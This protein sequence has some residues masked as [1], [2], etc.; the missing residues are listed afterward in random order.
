MKTRKLWLTALCALVALGTAS[1]S[2]SDDSTKSDTSANAQCGNGICEADE[3]FMFC[4]ADCQQS[5]AS[6]CGNGYCETDETPTSCP[7]DCGSLCSADGCA[8]DTPHP[9]NVGTCGNN[10]CESDES[11]NSCPEDCEAPSKCGNGVCEPE[12]GES[13]ITCS[14]DCDRA[15]VESC[16]N[17][18]CGEGE[19]YD[20][21]PDDC[22]QEVVCGDGICNV[23]GGENGSNCSD[24]CGDI[25]CGDDICMVGETSVTCP[26]D[27]KVLDIDTYNAIS[28][29]K[30]RFFYDLDIALPENDE[31]IKAGTKTLSNDDFFRYPY[32]S[33]LRT[34]ET[35]HPRLY[36]MTIP[37][38]ASNISFI[39]LMKNY[40]ETE[41]PGFSAVSAAFFRTSASITT[42]DFPTPE[43]SRQVNSCFQIV[44]VEKTSTHYGERVPLY[45]TFHEADTPSLWAANTLVLRPVPGAAMNPGD[46][47]VALVQDCLKS[48]S[49][50][51]AQSTKLA[52]IFKKTAPAEITKHTDE[53]VDAIVDLGYDLSKITAFTGFDTVDV[54]SEMMEMA[55]QLKGK[56]Y[57][58]KENG[59]AK[60]TYELKSEAGWGYFFSGEFKTVNFMEGEAPYNTLGTGQILLDEHGKLISKPKLETVRF[61]ISVPNPERDPMPQKGYPIIVYGHGTGGDYKTHCGNMSGTTSAYVDEGNWLLFAGVPTAMIGFD[62][63]LHGTRGNIAN[64]ADLY[65]GFF[66]NPIAIRE[67]WRQTVIDM[68]VLYD[69][70]E[71]G[72]LVLPNPT[73]SGD[74]IK[75]DPSYGLYMGHSQG[76]QEGGLL[77][78]LTD[79]IKSAFLSA[80]G[81]GITQSFM[82]LVISINYNGFKLGPLTV[83]DLVG[84]FFL[85]VNEGDLSIDAFITNHF[86][87][88]LLDP[89]EPLNFTRR[90]IKEPPK[91]WSSKNIAQTIGVGDQSTP[92]AAQLSMVASIGL[93]TVG[94]KYLDHDALALN[95]LAT[96]V[97]SPVTNNVTSAD[98]SQTVTGGAMQFNYTGSS[99]PHFVIYRM[100]AARNAYTDFFKSI[101]DNNGVPTISVNESKQS[102]SN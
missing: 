26:D 14:A 74:P 70:I 80:G 7:T 47:H 52:H 79:Q 8:D 53:Y 18:V 35:G 64:D 90:F 100:S 15:Y 92:N 83:A 3:S 59:V 63:V 28:D 49:H 67:S 88:P 25:F 95:G 68:L 73:G 11:S 60:G 17:G 43:E 5:A 87:Q 2:D 1:C 24:D 42:N 55:E 72:E 84:T 58:V 45:V 44:N 4:P 36:G 98:G 37:G 93:P 66:R 30:Y 10:V 40:I 54:V 61:G 50:K 57:I 97:S 78:G 86:V 81:G 27:C 89:I 19:D 82:D 76:A 102:G 29:I 22:P 75:F 31:E 6:Q 32:P 46:K 65:I 71:R 39:K 85:G 13:Y 96:P 33:A 9:G 56:G 23:D 62:A 94:Q 77:L 101:I 20:I 69:L 91:G 99:N 41:R 51:I 21:C 34:D 48:N 38:P 12:E 16:G